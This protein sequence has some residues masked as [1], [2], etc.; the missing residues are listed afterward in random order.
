ME[1]LEAELAEAVDGDAALRRLTRNWQGLR[2]DVDKAYNNKTSA[3]GKERA[4]RA[5]KEELNKQL[6]PLMYFEGSAWEALAATLPNARVFLQ[7]ADAGHID[8][9]HRQLPSL[10]AKGGRVVATR[11]SWRV[12]KAEG[13]VEELKS[14]AVTDNLVTRFRV[15][16]DEGVA[17]AAGGRDRCQWLCRDGLA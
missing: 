15:Y 2:D 11:R 9:E 12:F 14:I 1:S 10:A 4:L 5:E 3:D 8:R 17:G 6:T 7:D 16:E 13:Y